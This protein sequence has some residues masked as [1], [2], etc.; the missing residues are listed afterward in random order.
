M[1]GLQTN[2]AHWFTVNW[3]SGL[4]LM[5]IYI[6]I[7]TTEAHPKGSS[8]G[9]PSA[10]VTKVIVDAVAIFLLLSNINTVLRTLLVN[11]L[12]VSVTLPD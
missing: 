5:E 8:K 11:H 6:V 10:S 4:E 9:G 3:M 2:L 1:F 12:W 7:S